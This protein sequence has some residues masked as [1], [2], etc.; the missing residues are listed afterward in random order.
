[1]LF[2]SDFPRHFMVSTWF[3]C[4]PCPSS[5]RPHFKPAFTT[6]LLQAHERCESLRSSARCLNCSPPLGGAGVEPIPSSPPLC[7]GWGAVGSFSVYYPCSVNPY[8]PH[9]FRSEVCP[10]PAA[11]QLAAFPVTPAVSGAICLQPPLEGTSPQH[12]A[13]SLPLLHAAPSS[14]DRSRRTWRENPFGAESSRC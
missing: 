6:E 3:H 5:S 11:P 14:L 10:L 12:T 13:G 4:F 9:V 2:P 7:E 8:L 1:M